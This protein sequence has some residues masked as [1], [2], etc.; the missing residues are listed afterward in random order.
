MTRSSRSSPSVTAHTTS[1]CQSEDAGDRPSLGLLYLMSAP[2]VAAVA[3]FERL[4]IAGLNYTGYLWMSYL[5][6]GI[7]LVLAEKN[8]NPNEVMNFPWKPWAIWFGYVWLSL[9]WTQHLQFGNVREAVQISMPLLIGVAGSLFVRTMPQLESLVRAYSWTLVPLM[10]SLALIRLGVAEALGLEPAPRVLGLTAALVG[11]VF[12]SGIQQR[13]MVSLLGWGACIALTTISGSRMATVVL[14]IVPAI[15]PLYRRK[16]TRM[17]IITGLVGL[18]IA[19]FHTPVFQERFFA[20]GAGSLSD[21][22]E[23]NFL[24]FGR[25]ETWPDLWEEAWQHP[26][27][28]AGVGSICAKLVEMDATMTHPHNDYLRIGFD[29]GLVGLSVFALVAVWQIVDFRRNMARTSGIRQQVFAAAYLGFFVFLI[30]SITDNT[31]VYNLWYMDPLF[32][33]MGAAYGC[34]DDRTADKPETPSHD[35]T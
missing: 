5:A 21:V 1:G 3:C 17:A 6:A 26:V 34:V 23:G 8:S 33:L 27:F 15:H 30:T 2:L 20:D 4:E 16:L 9:A 22:F 11:C 31:L 10:F 18:G 7:V 25:F 28:G 19:L 24:S 32:V 29:G 14:L 35:E 12:L 13:R